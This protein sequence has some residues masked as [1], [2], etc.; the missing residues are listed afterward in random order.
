MEVFIARVP[1]LPGTT[2]AE[3]R[4]PERRKIGGEI[5]VVPKNQS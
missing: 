5:R 2:R 3:N 1:S 4:Q